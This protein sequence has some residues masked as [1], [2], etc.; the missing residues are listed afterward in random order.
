VVFLAPPQNFYQ[1]L[2][3]DLNSYFASVEQQDR[4]ELRGKPIVITPLPS[5]STCAIAASYEAKAF[6][7]K[8]GTKIYE[9]R[10]LCP[11]LICVPARHHLYVDYHHKILAE[12]VRHTPINKV[13]SID[14][15]SSRLPPNKR[16]REAVTAL[17]GR[18]KAGIRQNVGEAIRCSIGIAPNAFLAKTATDM[19][20]PDGLVILDEEN[21]VTRLFSLKLTDLCGISSRMEYRL[22]CSGVYSVEQFWNLSPKQARAVWGSVEGERFWYRLRGYDIPDVE[23]KSSMIG[24]SRILDP[25]LRSP[26]MA[27]Q[28]ARRLTIKAAMRLRRSG[29]FAADFALSVREA[30]DGGEKFSMAGRV[31]P[32]QDN[33]TFLKILD[34]LWGEMMRSLNPWKI[35]KISVSLCNLHER[36]QITPDLF[37]MASAPCVREQEKS[38]V[39]SAVMDKINQKYGAEAIRLG[40]S[41]RTQA[42]YVG[43]K[44]AF[45][46]I[47]DIEEFHE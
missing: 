19:M 43:T 41:P 40:I 46:R 1:W 26:E 3:L 23:T 37:D 31:T 24:H 28:V 25:E 33:F 12:V 34:G 20:K 42:G 4:P 47:P 7:I 11:D 45:H 39:L 6:G 22:N 14:E 9:A 13:W 17:A 5:D 38:N 44:I 8:T 16:N 15:L 36:N 10:R 2:F 29:F 30:G 18:I 27:K 35:K 32:A 21:L